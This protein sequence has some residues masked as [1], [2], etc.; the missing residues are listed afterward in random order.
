M[1]I[2]AVFGAGSIGCYIGGRLAATGSRVVLIGRQYMTGAIAGTGLRLSDYRGHDAH[3]EPGLL[4]LANDATAAAGAHLVLVT[5]KSGA[6]EAAARALGYSLKDDAVVISLQNGLHNTAL[7]QQYLPRQAVLAGMVPFNV[8]QQAPGHFHQGSE[9]ELVVERSA[10]LAPFLPAFAAAGLPLEQSEDITSVQWAKLLLNLNNAV[11]A[12][13][14]QPL[15]A[16]LSQRAYRKVLAAAQREALA[17]LREQRQGLARLTPLPA[18]WIPALL[19]VPDPL[20]RLLANRMLAI[21]PQARSSMQD[22][23]AAGRRTEID[24]LQ[25]EILRLA[26]AHQRTA[27]VNARL[28]ELVHA[29]EQGGRREWSGSEL[30]AAVAPRPQAWADG[31]RKSR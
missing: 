20:F 25:G 7:L 31:H 29:A 14:G 3:V 2:I 4:E 15:K 23:L 27:P 8:T 19:D 5:V 11:N 13:S 21:D 16:E 10:R 30:L 9:G 18:H 17:L 1:P 24:S 12:L 26:R 6:T 22:D 28:L